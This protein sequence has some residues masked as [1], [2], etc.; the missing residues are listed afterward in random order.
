MQSGVFIARLLGPLLKTGFPLMKNTL[1][2]QVKYALIPLGLAAATAVAA[3]EAGIF[4]K[5]LASGTTTLI[6][7]NEKMNDIIKMIR[8]LGESSLLIKYASETI[9]NEA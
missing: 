6:I 8:S 5:I 7:S 2:P 4:E 1:K 3:V 9:E